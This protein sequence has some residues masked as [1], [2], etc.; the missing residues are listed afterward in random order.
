M[1]E[2]KTRC[3]VRLILMQVNHMVWT[4]WQVHG[5]WHSLQW[6]CSLPVLFCA[7]R[8]ILS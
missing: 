7:M 1:T 8:F 4:K 5:D 6:A 2:V 3:C